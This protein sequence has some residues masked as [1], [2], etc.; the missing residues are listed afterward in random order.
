MHPHGVFYEQESEGALYENHT[1]PGAAVQPGS[2]FTYTWKV[3]ERAGPTHSDPSSLFWLYHSHVDE[4]RDINTGLIGGIIIHRKGWNLEPHIPIKEFVSMFL[5]NDEN[6]SWY[7]AENIAQFA[8]NSTSTDG[9][10]YNLQDPDFVESNQM[11]AV[12]GRMYANLDGYVMRKN[13]RVRWHIA[14]LGNEVDLHSAHWHAA[15]LLEDG[16]RVDVSNL[17]PGST[18]TLD[19]QPDAVGKWLFHCH[20]NDHIMAGMVATY[21]VDNSTSSSCRSLFPS[22]LGASIFLAFAL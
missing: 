18:K 2:K 13:D 6:Q 20:V 19:M 17:L 14:A 1:T 15:T 4:P 11:H 22:L 12:N 7:I 3:P 9:D 21:Q 8:Q 5:V 10:E 16:H